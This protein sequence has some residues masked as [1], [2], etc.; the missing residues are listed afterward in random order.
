MTQGHTRQC[1]RATEAY[2]RECE[3]YIIKF[4]NHCKRCG[5][6]GYLADPYSDECDDA[7]PRC[8]EKELCPRCGGALSLDIEGLDECLSCG[9]LDCD[10]GLPEPP[11]CDCFDE[12]QEDWME[13]D[14]YEMEEV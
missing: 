11:E 8:L 2:R 13:D 14:L 3:E 4:P 5:G 12:E 1:D 7:C 9:W 6:W 10:E